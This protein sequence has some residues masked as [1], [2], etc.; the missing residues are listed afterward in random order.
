MDMS[1]LQG[2]GAGAQIVVREG[3]MQ[4]LSVKADVRMCVQRFVY[5]R[6][7]AERVAGSADG[8][9]EGNR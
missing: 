3:C 9:A 2:R 6:V 1:S 5:M 4:D 7:N 8:N